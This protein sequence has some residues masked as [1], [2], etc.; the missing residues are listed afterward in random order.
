MVAL[1]NNHVIASMGFK[2]G[3]MTRISVCTESM[4]FSSASKVYD[5]SMS[6]SSSCADIFAI[7]S[8]SVP[9]YELLNLC[10]SER[11]ACSSIKENK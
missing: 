2:L 7:I 8:D 9:R 10:I 4:I 6:L 1:D 11:Y 3:T 5:M